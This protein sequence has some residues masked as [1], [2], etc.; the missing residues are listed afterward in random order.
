MMIIIIVVVVVVF[1]F[2]FQIKSMGVFNIKNN[3]FLI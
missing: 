3:F 2:T 1:S